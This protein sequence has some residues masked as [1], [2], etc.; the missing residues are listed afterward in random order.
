MAADPTSA[1]IQAII[2]IESGGNPTAI[3]KPTKYGT[4]KGKYQVLDGTWAGYGGYANAAQAPEAV[5]DEFARTKLTGYVKQFGPAGAAVA[6]AAGPTRAADYVK[7][8]NDPRWATMM[9]GGNTSVADYV[10]K[11]TGGSASMKAAA[12]STTGGSAPTGGDHKAGEKYKVPADAVLYTVNGMPALV[13]SLGDGVYI[14]YNAGRVPDLDLTNIPVHNV[15]TQEFARLNVVDGGDATELDQIARNFGSYSTWW[16]H[17]VSTVFPPNSRAAHDPAVRRIIAEMAGRPDMSPAELQNRLNATPW[18]Q[19]LTD[20]AQKYN[21]ATDGQ[22]KQMV[23]EEAAQLAD[24]WQRN[25]GTAVDLNDPRIQALALQVATGKRGEGSVLW[26]DI[27]PVARQNTESPRSQQERD[28]QESQ[29]KRGNEVENKSTEVQDL[30][31]RWGVSVSPNTINQ[32]ANDITTGKKSEADLLSTLQ[33]QSKV[34][35]P[36]KDPQLETLTAAQ[37]WLDT[38]QR[39]LE[40]PSKGIQDSVIQQALNNGTPLW[41]FERQLKDR[42]E[43]L[44][45]K[46]AQDDVSSAMTQVGRTMGFN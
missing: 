25:V 21:Q 5:Q 18:Y 1:L 46:N 20:Q 19:G 22:K 15:S 35:Y 7:N 16:D 38:F 2:G 12:T 32:W 13:I 44:T 36:W 41:Q 3:G 4:A 6:W 45:T 42:P 37:P 8:P 9:V 28:S 24:Y 26:E 27:I 34:L 43:W 10:A 11:A 23:A 31:H 40:K 39:V 33:G 29:L 17:I 30:Y 14:K